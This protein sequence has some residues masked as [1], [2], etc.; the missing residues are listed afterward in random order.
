MLA[1][2]PA[3]AAEIP[4]AQA[5]RA[6]SVGDTA[7]LT[8]ALDTARMLRPWDAD[9]DMLGAC[10][11]A[12]L[13]LRGDTA[14]ATAADEHARRALARV[15]DSTETLRCGAQA[16]LSLGDLAG[17]RDQLDTALRLAPD[18]PELL[19]L[20]GYTYA[21]S[22]QLSQAAPALQAATGNPF[23]AVRAEALLAQV[24]QALDHRPEN[25]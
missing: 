2:V 24:R 21:A 3:V 18:D 20:S 25:G 11:L 4:L 5:Q 1:L 12:P 9:V 16:S 19:L 13:A 6:A 15:P 7:A 10:L 17:A 23:T 22:G 8:R 14:A